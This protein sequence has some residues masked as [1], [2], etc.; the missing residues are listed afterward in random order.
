MGLSQSDLAEVLGLRESYVTRWETGACTPNA[1]RLSEIA[2]RLGVSL[3]WLL[4]E[5]GPI[6]VAGSDTRAAAPKRQP[7]ARGPETRDRAS[8][9]DPRATIP[10]IVERLR[11][12]TSMVREV[13]EAGQARR[14]EARTTSGEA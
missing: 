1:I 13:L 2:D 9:G 12:E 8:L 14:R 6:H 5:Q 3:D 11:S 4:A 10:D 7:P